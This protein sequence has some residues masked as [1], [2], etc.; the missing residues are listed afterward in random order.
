MKAAFM[1]HGKLL[2]ALHALYSSL[3]KYNKPKSGLFLKTKLYRYRR[4]LNFNHLKRTQNDDD[5]ITENLTWLLRDAFWVALLSTLLLRSE[6]R[7]TVHYLDMNRMSEFFAPPIIFSTPPLEIVGPIWAAFP[8][9]IVVP[10]PLTMLLGNAAHK[11]ILIS[12]YVAK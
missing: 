12:I 2:Y 10:L 4:C 7:V 5:D 3:L 9:S 6:N 8:K 1:T 11:I